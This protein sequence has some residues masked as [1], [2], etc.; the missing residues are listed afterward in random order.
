M[1]CV[2]HIASVLVLTLALAGCG[3]VHEL[4]LGRIEAAG[5]AAQPVAPAAGSGGGVAGAAG[6]DDEGVDD[7]H[8]HDGE[9]NH[10]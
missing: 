2:L 8:G 4:S 9:G 7:G 1:M 6:R 5:A 10:R 3:S